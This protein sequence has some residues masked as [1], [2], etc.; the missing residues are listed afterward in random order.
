MRQPNLAPRGTA[1]AD[2]PLG[3]AADW[4]SEP[5]RSHGLGFYLD[6]LRARL[7]LVALIVIITLVASALFVAQTDKVYEAQA[8]LLV[9]PVP[10][11]PDYF[12]LGLVTESGDPTRDASTLAKLITSTAVADRARTTLAEERAASALRKDVTAEPVAQ[13]SIITVTA[14]ASDPDRAAGLANAF[15]ESV[16]AVRTE[17]LRTKL[18]DLI[19]NLR[20]QL[21]AVPSG[22]TRTREVLSSRVQT[23]VTL[24]ALGDPT[25]NIEARAI[26][27]KSPVAPRP[28][29]TMVA[30]LIAALVLAFGIVL[31]AHFLDTR[32]ER[33]ED[34]RGYRVPVVGRIPGEARPLAQRAPIRPE[35]LSPA[36]I[37][38]FHRLASTLA[39]RIDEGDRTIFVTAPGPNSGKTTTSINLAASLATF[40]HGVVLVDGDSRRPEIAQTLGMAPKLGLADVVTGRASLADALVDG[41]RAAGRMR[42]LAPT[43]G[44]FA[45]TPMSAEAADRLIHEATHRGGWL[46]VDG[47]ALSYAP[48]SLPLAKRAANV[49]IVVHLRKTR[50]RDLNDL[51]D[52]LMQQGITPDGFV[53]I[54]EKPR[55]IYR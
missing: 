36:A 34:L 6:L 30:S 23:L 50:V 27:P 28:V 39:A 31:G 13:S 7:W 53:V 43:L 3:V 55:T 41:D 46:I 48:D 32:V 18:N 1:P 21:A 11:A 5:P 29:L 37:D 2:R 51:A 26:P 24:R 10:A 44:E 47:A 16:I 12:G 14:K 25:L 33:E 8:D 19:P 22:E 40:D 42:V 54:G 52:L 9:T 35:D 20:K 15:A 17:R 38:A 49:L 45:P 4:F